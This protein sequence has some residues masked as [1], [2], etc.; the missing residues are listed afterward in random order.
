MVEILTRLPP[1]SLLRIRSFSKSL[2]SCIDSPDFIRKHTSRS[3]QRLFM[4]HIV[5]Y[6]HVEE[7]GDGVFFTFHAEDQLPLPLPLCG[8][9][10]VGITP[11][12]FPHRKATP[13]G[14]CNGL[15]LLFGC[16]NG[17]I[18]LWNPSIKRQLTLPDCPRR[19]IYGLGLGLGFDP[20][21]DDNKV[22]SIPRYGNKG[23]VESAFV[24]SMKTRD[25]RPIASS[26]PLYSKVLSSVCYLNGVLHWVVGHCFPDSEDVQFHCIM[27]FDLS[28]HEFGIIDLPKPSWLTQQLGIIQGSLV[29]LSGNGSDVDTWIWVRNR[30]DADAD[31]SWSLVFKSETIKA[32]AGVRK[33]LEVTNNGD[34]LLDTFWEGIQVYTP[35]T[36][37]LSRLM[38]FNDTSSLVDMNMYVETLEL[39]HMGTAC[40]DVNPLFLQATSFK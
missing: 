25:W 10:Y 27:T 19:C 18:S 11:V 17:V 35:K 9:G 23:I 31:A 12:Q 1:K 14:S 6:K 39:L 24:Y 21:T 4:T 7:Y 15:L 20:I 30:R 34:L 36:G 29:V 32:E 22:V 2:R 5:Q 33:A 26:M 3:P 8:G 28:T 13:L 37:E 16:L 38:D 40:E